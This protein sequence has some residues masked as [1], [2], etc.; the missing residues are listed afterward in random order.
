MIYKLKFTKEEIEENH[1]YFLER[2]SLYKSLGQDFT[3]SR[4]F[5]LEKAEQLKGKM[6]EI[7]SG[8][9][10]MTLALAQAGHRFISID[11][12]A[13]SLR[14]STLNLAY[15]GLLSNVEFHMM[16]GGAMSFA[17]RTFDNIIAVNMFHHID[18][19]DD[20]LSEIDRV[21]TS[22]GR[23][24]A[25]DFNKKGMDIIDSMHKKEERHH[26][27]TGVTKEYIYSYFQNLGYVIGE[28]K[29]SCHWILV[30]KKKSKYFGRMN[31]PT[32]AASIKGPCGDEIEF[33]LVIDN[34]IIKDIK[35]Y[36]EGCDDTIVCGDAVSRLV[37]GRSIDEALGISPKEVKDTLDDLPED[38]SHCTILAVSTL[39]R[40]IADY[41]LKK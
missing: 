11:N 2:I 7:G 28:F 9:G 4:E 3:K 23:L 13:E 32:A 31:D 39:Y 25:A 14:K 35:F 41:L 15:H 1:K 21:L 26:K 5:I 24:I 37:I 29:D 34:K 20:M 30:A 6:L 19:A 33:Y 36:A 22:D 8:N 40:A 10:Y 16:D 18:R 38:H 17:D 12:D 27:N